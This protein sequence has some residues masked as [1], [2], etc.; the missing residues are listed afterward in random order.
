MSKKR[1]IIDFDELEVA[2][3]GIVCIFLLEIIALIKGI[4]GTI[5]AAGISGIAGIVG[6]V[7]K[8]FHYKTKSKK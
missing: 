3:L 1:A 7:A 5:F 6:W 8:M 2:V 4:D